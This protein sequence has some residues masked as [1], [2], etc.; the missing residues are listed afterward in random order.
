MTMSAC[1]LRA[2]Q[3]AG[4]QARPNR[5]KSPLLAAKTFLRQLFFEVVAGD[6][7]H[8]GHFGEF[9]RLCP[10]GHPVVEHFAGFIAVYV[11]A[12]QQRTV[13]AGGLRFGKLAHRIHAVDADADNV[14]RFK[15]LPFGGAHAAQHGVVVH[16][17][18]Q[19]VFH[20]RMLNQHGVGGVKRAG[21]IVGFGRDFIDLFFREACG[22][23][24]VHGAG[25]A[26]ARGVELVSGNRHHSRF[27][28][29]PAAFLHLFI[30]FLALALA[31]FGRGHHHQRH[32]FHR[33]AFSG[34]ELVI[35]GDDFHVVATRFRD[36]RRAKF[37]VWRT[38]DKTLRPARRQAVDGVQGFLAIRHR[39][40][41]DFKTQVF[42]RFVGEF[43]F[44]LKP[45]LFRLFHQKTELHGFCDSGL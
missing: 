22:F 40:F 27:F 32:G 39:N 31:D 14:S 16:A 44:G 24:R 12:W 8:V 19:P 36:N 15:A 33:F 13:E 42:A 7:H 1:Y 21:D 20:F 23:Q 3:K 10:F 30:E 26:A 29:I 17:D 6:Q 45:R 41:D 43:P 4:A 34:H 28:Y 37:R 2:T 18:H 5:D 25:G 35:H 11:R 9:R 38:D